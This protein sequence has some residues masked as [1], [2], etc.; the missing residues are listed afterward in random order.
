[1]QDCANHAQ[2]LFSWLDSVLQEQRREEEAQAQSDSLLQVNRGCCRG[3]GGGRQGAAA[4]CSAC[5]FISHLTGAPG[6]QC[7]QC[8]LH[9]QPPDRD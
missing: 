8:V 4:Q 6:A 3:E 1:M 5:C 9:F 7:V 2:A